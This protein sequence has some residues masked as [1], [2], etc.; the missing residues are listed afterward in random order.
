MNSFGIMFE[1]LKKGGMGVD[2][3]RQRDDGVMVDA[4]EHELASLGTK[5][6]VASTAGLL[7]KL[8][9]VE[10]LEWAIETKNEANVFYKEKKFREAMGKYVECLAATDFGSKEAEDASESRSGGNVEVLVIPVLCNLAACCI[11]VEEFSKAVAF[12][13]QAIILRPECTKAQLRKGLGLTR[14]GEFE[15]ALE[16]FAIVQ[17]IA[18]VEGRTAQGEG[19]AASEEGLIE[20]PAA[21][22]KNLSPADWDRLPALILQ[23][24]RGQRQHKEQWKR[25]KQSLAKAFAKNSAVPSE[26]STIVESDDEVED[27][28]AQ[29]TRQDQLYKHAKKV[30]EVTK[31]RKE[32]EKVEPM[33]LAEIIVF[34]WRLFIDFV[35]GFFCKSKQQ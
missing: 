24:R 4:R 31:E 3:K 19:A 34:L 16:C 21:S 22:L 27:K 18:V 1:G 29:S 35:L 28:P 10:R 5:S 11:Q 30:P 25:Q 26:K 15:L 14:I 17:K 6:T 23:A 13:E 12:S 7:K 9:P 8:T 2:I 33:G 32:V 20:D